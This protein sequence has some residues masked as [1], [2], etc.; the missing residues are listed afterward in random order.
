MVFPSRWYCSANSFTRSGSEFLIAQFSMS[1]ICIWSGRLADT[2]VKNVPVIT[3]SNIMRGKSPRREEVREAVLADVL[4]ETEEDAEA[5]REFFVS[6]DRSSGEA[7]DDMETEQH[8]YMMLRGLDDLVEDSSRRA[9]KKT[10]S[11]VHC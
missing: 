4:L 8:M 5:V 10:V 3:V 6:Q 7:D 1:F 11:V 9:E 2:V